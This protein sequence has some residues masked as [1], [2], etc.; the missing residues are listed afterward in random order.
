MQPGVLPD[1]RSQ[2]RSRER[3]VFCADE[4]CT[5]CD[6][7]PCHHKDGAAARRRF[8]LRQMEGKAPVDKTEVVW[9]AARIM[10]VDFKDEE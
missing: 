5:L 1:W 7:S 4:P 3:Q 2:L 6:Q 10:T 8:Y 9:P